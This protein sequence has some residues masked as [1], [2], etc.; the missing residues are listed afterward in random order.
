[1]RSAILPLILVVSLLGGCASPPPHSDSSYS[2]PS[3]DLDSFEGFSQALEQTMNAKDTS[4]FVERVD[5]HEFARRSLASLGLP[6]VKDETVNT[7]AGIMEKA[8]KQRYKEIFSQVQSA[9]F[10]RMM[11]TDPGRPDEAVSLVRIQP[12]G[13]GINYWKVY[14]RRANGRVSIVDWFSYSV[15]DLASRSLGS[16]VLQAGIAAT[17]PNS[18]GAEAI[19]VYL[20]A[21]RSSDLQ[22]QVDAYQ[23]LP[24]RLKNNPLLM[25]AYSQAAMKISEEVYRKALYELAPLYR[26]NDNYALMLVDYYVFNEEYEMAHQAID[27]VAATI[28]QDAGLDSLHAGIA[29]QTHNYE[30]A[31]AYARDGI[32][33]ETDYED[34]YW[35]LLDALVYSE[36]YADAVLVLNIL[37]QGFNYRFDARQMAALEGY[38]DFSRSEAFSGWRSA[39]AH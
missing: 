20:A 30:R 5:T 16:F 25:F 3:A 24:A 27:T 37:E 38:E 32:K 26:K 28:G 18:D 29:L 7:Y 15:G 10:A 21:A 22:G 31:I 9:R 17:D 12:E 36:N 39:S 2:T 14:L 34:N 1:M 11:P 6:A 8:L 4:L 33:R 23:H 13:G 19:K 35:V